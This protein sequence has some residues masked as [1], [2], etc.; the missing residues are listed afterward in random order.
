MEA[1]KTIKEIYKEIYDGINT[2]RFFRSKTSD[3]FGSSAN[4]YGGDNR[5]D[6]RSGVRED[7]EEKEQQGKQ[8][9]DKC[10]NTNYSP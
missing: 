4:E 6:V 8:H 2:K 10:N 1:G 3:G 7:I 9:Y 5:E